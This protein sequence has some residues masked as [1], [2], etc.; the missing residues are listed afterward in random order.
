MNTTAVNVTKHNRPRPY[1]EADK[2]LWKTYLEEGM[3]YRKVA[4][5]VGVHR[6]T[7]RKHL[8]GMGWTQEEGRKL[9]TFMKHHN[10]K[11]AQAERKNYVAKPHDPTH[12]REAQMYSRRAVGRLGNVLE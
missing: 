9:G 8:P 7:I 4:E 5:V 12:D 10:E 3:P 1:T 11:M 2:E 6:D